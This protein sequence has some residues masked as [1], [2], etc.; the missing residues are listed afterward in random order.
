M[1]PQAVSALIATS[2]L[3][4]APS[5]LGFTFTS[6]SPGTAL[7]LN[8]SS[9]YIAWT[10]VENEQFTQVNLTFGSDKDGFTY[11]IATN[12]SIVQDHYTWN[13]ANVSEA[14]QSTKIP[15]TEGLDFQFQAEAY[16]TP[17][18]GDS[19]TTPSGDFSVTGYPYRTNA[20]SL[21]H[22]QLGAVSL[23]LAAVMCVW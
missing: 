8:S 12:V 3:A 19:G 22:P 7:D 5:A 11:T 14:L 13:P 20:A 2:L 17:D 21:L 23:A 4:K 18:P 1:R 10:H 16:N 15:L 9:I 6:P